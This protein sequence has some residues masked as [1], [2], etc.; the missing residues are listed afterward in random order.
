MTTEE[1]ELID[2]VKG[3]KAELSRANKDIERLDNLIDDTED[4]L[5]EERLNNLA[6]VAEGVA[7]RKQIKEERLKNAALNVW[8]EKV[9]AQME[10]IKESSIEVTIDNC[11]ARQI[12]ALKKE[13]KGYKINLGVAEHIQNK[14]L[15][16]NIKNNGE[17]V[18]IIMSHFNFK[19]E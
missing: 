9:K 2:N 12:R 7:R 4:D 14:R 11:T 13:I 10:R 6:L 3:L 18:G 1:K 19:G 8:V 17:A 15:L 5:K 16:K